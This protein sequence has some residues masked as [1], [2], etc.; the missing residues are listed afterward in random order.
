[1]QSAKNSRY[2]DLKVSGQY[3]RLANASIDFKLNKASNSDPLPVVD[4]LIGQLNASPSI[5]RF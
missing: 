5:C 2:P 3:Q 1:L 4:Q